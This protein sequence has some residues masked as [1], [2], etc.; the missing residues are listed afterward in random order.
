MHAGGSSAAPETTAYSCL[1]DYQPLGQPL[2][3]VPLPRAQ[4]QLPGGVTSG[5]IARQC[6]AA[7]D[8]EPRCSAFQALG[9][10]VAG[11]ARCS[12]LQATVASLGSLL[13]S[14]AYLRAGPEPQQL[15]QLL[16][17]LAYQFD[18]ATGDDLANVAMALVQFQYLPQGAGCSLK[19]SCICATRADLCTAASCVAAT[20]LRHALPRHTCTATHSQAVP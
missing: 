13:Y 10:Y 6:A 14:L 16:D 5:H 19:L 8:A 1:E 20:R 9:P 3:E 7:C 4:Q 15:Q 17:D 18:D 2:R 11:G 12:L